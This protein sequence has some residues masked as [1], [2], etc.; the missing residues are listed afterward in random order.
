MMHSTQ[1]LLT[2]SKTGSETIPQAPP[3]V[4]ASAS[5]ASPEEALSR[6]VYIETLGC[7]MNANDSELMMGLLNKVSFTPVSTPENADFIILNTCQIRE[8]A[9]EKA[10]GY[11]EN[12]KRLKRQRPWLKIAMAGCVAQQA[13]AQVFERLP[14]VDLVIGTQNMHQLPELAQ[15]LFPSIEDTPEQGAFTNAAPEQPESQHLTSPRQRPR[16]KR[17]AV[18]KGTQLL[19]TDRQKTFSTYDYVQDVAP[20]RQSQFSAWV[21]IIEGCDYFCTYCVV[22]YTRGRQISRT[23]ESIVQEVKRLAQEG[24]KEVTLLG[25]TVDAYG[26]DFKDAALRDVRLEHLF[27][28][29]N[30]IDG[31]ERIRFMTSHPLDLS[32]AIIEAIARLPKVMPYIHIPMQS[33]DDEV[34]ARMKRGYTRAQYFALVDKIQARIP[35]VAISGDYIV[36]FPGETE[37]QFQ[38]TIESVYRSNVMAVNTA[39]YS[40]RKQTPA[41]IWEARNEANT[42]AIED[43]EKQARLQRLNSAVTDQAMRWAQAFYGPY[44]KNNTPVE[45]LVEGPSKRNPER[46][47]GRTPQNKVV[48]FESRLGAPGSNATLAGQI[49]PVRLTRIL[50]W[51]LLGEHG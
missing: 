44:L 36:G 37:A 29:L 21:T 34:L 43:A 15:T 26:K 33:G 19:A 17:D 1:D 4:T 11:L 38:D 25:Q 30:A 48:N 9:E 13:Q 12:L 8:N 3:T 42:E 47:T 7:Q 39:A 40:A 5:D 46:W 28:R 23:P 18:P 6:R 31:L 35:D 45:V 14:F 32:D 51:S 20:L 2:S 27:E 10:Y 24:Y 49:V 41:A 50:A 16:S 22:P